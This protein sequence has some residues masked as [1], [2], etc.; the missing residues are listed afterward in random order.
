M[1]TGVLEQVHQL[2][3]E[4]ESQGYALWYRGQR[5]ASW[6]LLSTMHRHIN[7]ALV[8][9]YGNECPLVDENEKIAMMRDVYKMLFHR[10]RGR[11]LQLLADYER[12]DWGI[13]F[14]MQHLGLP[15]T[16]LDWTENFVCALY[17]AQQERQRSDDAAIFV[18][19][20]DR[21]NE[22]V[23]GKAGFVTLGGD[24]SRRTNIDTASYHPAILRAKEE[25]E[26][27]D[28]T[29]ETIA[30]APDLTNPRMVAQRSAFTLCGAS[31]EPLE[32]KYPDC[33]TRLVLPAADF[34]DAAAFLELAGATHFGYFPDLEGLRDDLLGKLERDVFLAQ[35][36]IAKKPADSQ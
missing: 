35:Q 25:T 16:L 19:N 15:T 27:K 8:S 12:S 7:K 17:F 14:A 18:L 31:F 1:W 26:G 9:V 3:H 23:I 6:V 4:A 2:Q 29:M 21:L 10:F 20:P 22:R 11:A 33:V 5:N 30:V 24:A 34:H 36:S 13:V 28:G 32:K